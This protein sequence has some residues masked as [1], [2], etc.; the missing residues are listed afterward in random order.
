MPRLSH[1]TRTRG[2]EAAWRG[3]DRSARPSDPRILRILDTS[4]HELIE[5]TTAKATEAGWTGSAEHLH[6]LA[7]YINGRVAVAGVH[8]TDGRSEWE[9]T[10]NAVHLER[11]GSGKSLEDDVRRVALNAFHESMHARYSTSTHPQVQHYFA[12]I[13]R[14]HALGR[15]APVEFL[16]I[17]FNTLEDER[18]MRHEAAGSQI[19]LKAMSQFRADVVADAEARYRRDCKE[20]PWT[21]TPMDAGA[22]FFVALIARVHGAGSQPLHPRI[23]QILLDASEAI[24]GAVEGEMSQCV[25]AAYDLLQLFRDA[26]DDLK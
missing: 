21:T 1:G 9:R 18:I 11:P 20:E 12:S 15:T 19:D 17:V 25:D 23:E 5:A 4:V 13:A 7:E 22:Q 2:R 24:D 26:L 6:L 16:S 14:L 8:W 3:L 10:A